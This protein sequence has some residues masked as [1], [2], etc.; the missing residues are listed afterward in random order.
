MLKRWLLGLVALVV[1]VPSVA[2]AQD[3][4][5]SPIIVSQ[6]IEHPD[7][8][9]KKVHQFKPWSEPTVSQV[10]FMISYEAKKWGASAAKLESVIGCESEFLWWKENGS[11]YGLGQFAPSTFSRGMST[12]KS[13][14]VQFSNNENKKK[15]SYQVTTYS[16]GTVT[17]E[18]YKRVKITI[19]H[20]NRG[21]IPS[22]PPIK[23]GWAQ[24]RIMA[25]AFSGQ[26]AVSAGEWVC[27]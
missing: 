14:D 27:Q 21:Q 12:I 1:I 17:R 22:S 5:S 23:H 20:V 24:V 18:K 2:M 10:H 19:H 6:Q 8:W 16:D 25:Q 3:T 9:V 26:S 11:H 7:K 15:W 13:R 4:G